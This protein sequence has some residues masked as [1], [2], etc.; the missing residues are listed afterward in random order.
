[1]TYKNKT[2]V[3]L[4]AIV[5]ISIPLA[6]AMPLGHV[7]WQQYCFEKGIEVKINAGDFICDVE[8]YE[9]QSQVEQNT[10]DISAL[11]GS[12]NYIFESNNLTSV[13]NESNY[14]L[15]DDER[16]IIVSGSANQHLGAF[17][18]VEFQNQ[19]GE[20]IDSQIAPVVEGQWE[21]GLSDCVAWHSVDEQS[22]VLRIGPGDYDVISTF[23]GESISQTLT[24]DYFP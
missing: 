2:M 23:N 7:A 20:T 17:V 18:V 15:D 14:N 22:C 12:N 5:A 19:F 10:A 16:E 8:I 1:M 6:F 13:L 9:L 21:T 3:A 24:V 11:I 4:L